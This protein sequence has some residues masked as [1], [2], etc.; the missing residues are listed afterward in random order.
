[1][2][3]DAAAI[4][5]AEKLFKAQKREEEGV[6]AMADYKR[7]VENVRKRT[8]ALRAAR[9]AREGSESR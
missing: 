5:R 4:A 2:S 3:Q 1:M 9:I 7:E 6:K 8:A